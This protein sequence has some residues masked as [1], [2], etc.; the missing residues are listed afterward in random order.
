[1]IQLTLHK[2]KIS[3]SLHLNKQNTTIIMDDFMNLAQQSGMSDEK[4]QAVAGGLFAILQEH[5][6]P[7]QY[8]QV[9][10]K[11]PE[12]DY[13]AQQHREANGSADRGMGSS[14][15]SWI[16]KKN[17]QG[18]NGGMEYLIE[19]LKKHKV[20]VAE[21]IIFI[22]LALW[23]LKREFGIDVF[24]L[25]G[26]NTASTSTS[27]NTNAAATNTNNSSGMFGS[28]NGKNTAD[29]SNS[30][31]LSGTGTYYNQM[32]AN[33]NSGG[34]GRN[35]APTVVVPSFPVASPNNA[36]VQSYPVP[37]SNNNNNQYNP[38][39]SNDNAYAPS[40]PVPPNNNNN[41]YNP[42]QADNVYVPSYPVN[43]DRNTSND[44]Y[45]QAPADPRVYVPNYAS[46]TTT[47][48]NQYNQGGPNNN[49]YQPSYPPNGGYNNQY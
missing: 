1:V 30:S 36:Y 29:S 49:V 32:F 23:L 20:T 47:N 19:T 21:L 37:T 26:G 42:Y 2:N 48:N 31:S 4:G 27:T 43:S 40:Y 16:T 28:M 17:S 12:F 24:H 15:L 8:Q 22:P 45:N 34:D 13:L 46:S 33:N 6:N 11:I 14:V 3:I 44:E 35:A 38:Y 10:T 41:Q 9:T 7:Q 18:N 25:F 5:M 39:G